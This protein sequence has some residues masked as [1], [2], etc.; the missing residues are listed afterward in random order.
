MSIDCKDEGDTMTNNATNIA[1]NANAA[2]HA[3]PKAQSLPGLFEEMQALLAVMPGAVVDR[4]ATLPTEEE[5][6]EM[7]DNMPV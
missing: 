2:L 1:A 7:F 6:E 5:V 4:G 3:E